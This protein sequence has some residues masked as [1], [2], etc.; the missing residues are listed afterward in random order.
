MKFYAGTCSSIEEGSK[1]KCIALC[2]MH[3]FWINLDL[4]SPEP[5]YDGDDNIPSYIMFPF[6]R[7]QVP[8]TKFAN[9]AS[10]RKWLEC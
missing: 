7:K 4:L 8:E 1:Q 10:P 9:A 2:K 6:L 3:D 5:G